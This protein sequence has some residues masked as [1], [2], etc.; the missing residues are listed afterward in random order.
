MAQSRRRKALALALALASVLLPAGP[1]AAQTT[2][3]SPPSPQQADPDPNALKLRFGIEYWV[4]ASNIDNFDF[5]GSQD[6]NDNFGWQRIKPFFGLRKRWFELVLQGQ[7]A[8]SYGV[9]ER[10]SQRH[11]HLRVGHQSARLRE[12]LRDDQGQGRRDAQGGP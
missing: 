8:R 7:D 12:G 1:A 3:A 6:D 4:R 9:P 10:V 11:A 2:P 5:D